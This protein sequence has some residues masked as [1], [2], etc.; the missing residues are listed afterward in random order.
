MVTGPPLTRSALASLGNGIYTLLYPYC[1]AVKPVVYLARL[2]CV[3][4][5]SHIMAPHAENA[6]GLKDNETDSSMMAPLESGIP[7]AIAKGVMPQHATCVLATGFTT[8]I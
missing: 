6:N 8:N 7:D 2:L 1:I 5:K 3:L 4:F